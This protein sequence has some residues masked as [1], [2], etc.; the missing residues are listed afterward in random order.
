MMVR[1]GIDMDRT[2]CHHWN[3]EESCVE[4]RQEPTIF[5]D[6]LDLLEQYGWSS[7]EQTPKELIG[8]LEQR[9]LD[10]NKKRGC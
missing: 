7:F 8:D 4:C 5:E 3:P 2:L 1:C 10:R 6:L 9:I